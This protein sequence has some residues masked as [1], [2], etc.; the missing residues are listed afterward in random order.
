MA[1]KPTTPPSSAKPGKTTPSPDKVEDAKV[2]SETPPPKNPGAKPAAKPKPASTGA[3]PDTKAAAAKTETPA[4]TA[5]KPDTTAKPATPPKS[6]APASGTK[7]PPASSDAKPAAST[8]KPP[9]TP[10]ATTPPPQKKRGGML[11]LILGGVIAAVIGYGLAQVVPDGWPIGQ[12]PEATAAL[13]ARL[14]ALEGATDADELRAELDATRTALAAAEETLAETQATL[15][16]L[17]TADVGLTDGLTAS[18]E[19]AASLDARLTELEMRP[20]IDLSSLDNS[21]AFEAELENL[22]AEIAEL[23]DA[24]RAEIDA[25]RTAADAQIAA[26]REE[27]TLLEQR[28]AEAADREATRAALSRVLTALDNGEGYVAELETLQATTDTAIPDVLSANAADGVATVSALQARFPDQAREA[29]AAMRRAN[30]G[31]ENTV[32]NFFRNQLGVRSL[33][34][35][36]GD[37][38]DAVLSRVQAAV[39]QGD[40]QTALTE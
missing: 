36:E 19:T 39:T 34:A 13:E 18:G 14:D 35:Q 9:S 25:A 17:R 30:T 22:R 21:D 8:T 33:D 12:D 11:G 3:K 27:A 38:P 6:E 15:D 28:A 23:S 5:A 4:T 40:L 26:A 16:E 20:Q 31:G 7:V 24:T 10:P 2:V 29:L 1:R 37:T 32:G